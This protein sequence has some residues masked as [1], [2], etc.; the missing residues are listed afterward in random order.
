MEAKL[1]ATGKLA[2]DAAMDA[3]ANATTAAVQALADKIAPA[4]DAFVAQLNEKLNKYNIEVTGRGRE[5]RVGVA[6]AAATKAYDPPR[7]SPSFSQPGPAHRV[8]RAAPRHASRPLP[9]R[10]VAGRGK[11]STPGP[12]HRPG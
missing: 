10:G 8:Q 1:N 4:D 12:Q 5:R 2:T 6:R 3:K 11:R 7:P 9:H